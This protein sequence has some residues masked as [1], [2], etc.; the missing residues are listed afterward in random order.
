MNKQSFSDFIRVVGVV[1]VIGVLIYLLYQVVILPAPDSIQHVNNELSTEPP[2]LVEK[3]SPRATI[4]IV[5]V[6]VGLLAWMFWLTI[7]FGRRLSSRSYLGPLTRDALK[8]AEINRIEDDLKSDLRAGVFAVEIDV[9]SKQ[10]RDKY[11]IPDGIDAPVLIPGVILEQYYDQARKS[12]TWQ[13]EWYDW[14]SSE[15]LESFRQQIRS[16]TKQKMIEERDRLNEIRRNE[17]S[18]YPIS[19]EKIRL[20][21]QEIQRRFEDA[22]RDEQV[23]LYQKARMEK[24]KEAQNHAD[25]L[26]PS[27]DVSAFG[28]GWVFVLEFTT[29]IFIIFATL[30]LGFVEVL[31]SEQ[32]GTILAAIAGYVLGK[33][34]TIKGADGVE[35]VRG[36]D[37][38]TALM[39]LL[40]RQADTRT[41][42]DDE[43][44]ALAERVAQLEKELNNI[45]VIVPDLRKKTFDDAEKELKQKGLLAS[46]K[47]VITD[48]EEPGIVFEQVPA[49]K[50]E[51]A[52]GSA[53]ILLVAAQKE[54]ED[55]TTP[56]QKTDQKDEEN[57]GSEQQSDQKDEEN[58]ES[59]QQKDDNSQV[60]DADKSP[61]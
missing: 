18:Q 54:S 20:I 21:D 45:T 2:G 12:D 38:P 39:D 3:L 17:P 42:T 31:S 19:S 61:A 50:E 41:K 26:L 15:D 14:E 56:E 53:V 28:G 52:K 16:L 23:A 33:S 37:Q 13:N 55:G 36:A 24:R 48:S 58:K 43:K 29:I 30:A 1:V 40:A 22:Y 47:D 25:R 7:D 10:W 34:T 59:E 35:T 11:D 9:N 57:K 6:L 4:S 5:L 8:R 27:I 44:K 46:R 51:L 32:I 60:S 49:G